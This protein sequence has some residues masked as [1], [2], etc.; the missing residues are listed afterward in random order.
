MILPRTLCLALA[1]LASVCVL[2]LAA[3]AISNDGVRVFVCG[4]SFHQFIDQPLEA[5]AV[6]AGHAGHR[7]VG[8]LFIGGSRPIQIWNLPNEKNTAKSILRAGGT[9]VFTL[10]PHE[11]V[12]DR[13]I[14]LY[15]DLAFEHN[16]AVRVLLQVSW[17]QM[18]MENPDPAFWRQRAEDYMARLRTQARS[19]NARH[20]RDFVYLVPAGPALLTLWERIQAGKVPGVTDV[21]SLFSDKALHPSPILKNL[22]SYCWFAAVYHESPVGL[23]ALDGQ[24][25]ANVDR[26]LQQ[27]AWDTVTA[28]PMGGASPPASKL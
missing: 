12:P 18:T 22:I 21:Q 4:H 13:G 26:V 25:P 8:K 14:D 9:D 1:A 24:V 2:P 6:E 27:I 3:Q 20:G 15:A 19:I 23:K 5:L 17:S 10:S 28:E 7:T 11:E 16:L